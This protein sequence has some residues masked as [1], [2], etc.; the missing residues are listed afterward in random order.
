MLYK[1]NTLNLLPIILVV[2]LVLKVNH[3]TKFGTYLPRGF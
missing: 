3:N 2:D 1:I